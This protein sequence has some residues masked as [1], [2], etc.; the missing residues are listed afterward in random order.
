M[1]TGPPVALMR[2]IMIGFVDLPHFSDVRRN[3]CS[4]L[5][6]KMYEQNQSLH[7]FVR[8]KEKIGPRS[9]SKTPLTIKRFIIKK[10]NNDGS[11]R[12]DQNNFLTEWWKCM[13]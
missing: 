4:R 6:R 8:E 3:K 9:T 2:Q 10:C 1:I 13:L 5:V 12:N 11:L 7:I